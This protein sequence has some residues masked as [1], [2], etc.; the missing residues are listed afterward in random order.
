MKKITLL[1]ALFI[2]FLTINAQSIDWTNNVEWGDTVTAGS[3]LSIDVT[4]DVGTGNDL[5][6]MH[7]V[8]S[9]YNTSSFAILENYTGE[10]FPVT[11]DSPNSGSINVQLVLDPNAPLDAD[12]PAGEGIM[13]R[14][15]MEYD[16]AGGGLGYQNDNKDVTYVAATASTKD[17]QKETAFTMYPN[18]VE[19]T[20]YLKGQ[21]LPSVYKITNTLGKTVQEGKFNGSI[22]VSNITSGIYFLIYDNKSYSKFLKK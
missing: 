5:N 8:L 14:V 17:F 2:G 20:I 13:I 6:Y 21:D 22:D 4:Y 15:Y 19:N 3:T 10:Q 11:E 12:L 16:L 1:F 9:R 7:V 18:P